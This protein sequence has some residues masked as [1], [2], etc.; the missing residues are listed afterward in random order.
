MSAF[1]LA[2]AVPC[3]DCNVGGKR[4]LL[5]KPST[6]RQD[7]T[8]HCCASQYT[9]WVTVTTYDHFLAQIWSCDTET[10]GC[11]LANTRQQR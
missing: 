1:G 7:I 4:F 3:S 2:L 8:T 5:S 6:A 10:N 9:A 11:P